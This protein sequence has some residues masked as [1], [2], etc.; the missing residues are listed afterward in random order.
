MAYQTKPKKR[1]LKSYTDRER[2]AY[3][4]GKIDGIRWATKHIGK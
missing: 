3:V 4:Q 2:S 1:R